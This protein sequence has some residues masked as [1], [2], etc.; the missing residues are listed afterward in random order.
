MT[1]NNRKVSYF[2]DGKSK[3]NEKRIT[4]KMFF[5][6]SKSFF[7]S[8]HNSPHPIPNKTIP[9]LSN[10]ANVGNYY[11]GS[12]HPMKPHRIR[13]THNLLINYGMYK[14]MQIYVS[15]K[16]KEMSFFFFDCLR[17]GDE[18][19]FL[20]SKTIQQQKKKPWKRPRYA[21]EAD[22]T[23]FHSDDYVDFLRLVTPDNMHEYSRQ[24]SKCNFSD[25][26]FLF[27][28]ACL[29]VNH[30]PC[31]SSFQKQSTLVR[32]VPCLMVC[33]NSVKF[34]QEVH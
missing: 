12:G 17:L 10:K 11:Y 30:Y 34:Q 6:F 2:Y 33:S 29:I 19:I 7:F 31:S 15:S 14:K 8:N 1:T 23:K 26:F 28:F 5:F 3:K 25:R 24:L 16:K 27:F 32:I 20:T 9:S 13:M 21:T 22:M 18:M 4:N